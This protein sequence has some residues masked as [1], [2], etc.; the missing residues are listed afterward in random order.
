MLYANRDGMEGLVEGRER[1]DGVDGVVKSDAF[2]SGRM[3]WLNPVLFSKFS[4]SFMD[5]NL[6]K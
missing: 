5:D 3:N 6:H 1:Q 2:M 4:M